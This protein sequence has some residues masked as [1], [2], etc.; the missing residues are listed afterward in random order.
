MLYSS[1]KILS[2]Y[3][4]AES[5]VSRCSVFFFACQWYINITIAKFAEKLQMPWF[6]KKIHVCVEMDSYFDTTFSIS[7]TLHNLYLGKNYSKQCHRN[8]RKGKS[9]H[10]ILKWPET[11]Y[12]IIQFEKWQFVYSLTSIIPKKKKKVSSHFKSACFNHH[13]KESKGEKLAKMAFE[14]VFLVWV[15][16]N[17]SSTKGKRPVWASAVV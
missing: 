3:L 9:S 16:S 10:Y 15:S 1:I 12:K 7:I 2:L 5:I 17:V 14:N 8:K 4:K 6:L 11:E 13:F